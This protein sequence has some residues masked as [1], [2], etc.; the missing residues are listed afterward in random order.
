MMSNFTIKKWT[1]EEERFVL[2]QLNIYKAV[3]ELP[4][5]SMGQKLGRSP[6]SVRKKAG[7]LYESKKSGYKW[8]KDESKD[9]F[10]LYLEGIPLATIIEKLQDMYEDCYPTLDQ[11]EKELKRVREAWSKHIRSYAEG[12]QLP[13]A[14]HFS[15]DTIKFYISNYGTDKDFVRK[16]LHG[17]IKNG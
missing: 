17:K 6:D 9:A 2:E 11:L 4:L 12:R 16:V 7:R 15:L 8:D 5:V 13:V 1:V 10:L 14:K 3:S